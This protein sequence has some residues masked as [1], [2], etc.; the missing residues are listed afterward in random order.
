MDVRVGLGN[1]THRLEQGSGLRI[2]GVPVACA[3]ASVAVS[4]GDVLLH[5]LVDALLGAAGWGDI[6]DRYPENKT[7]RG[8][9]S[10]RFVREVMLD[11]TLRGARVGNV[12]CVVELEKPRLGGLKE[13]IR[14]NIA[15]LLEVD[16]SRVGVKAKTAEGLGPIGR[17]EAFSAQAVVLLE[18][19]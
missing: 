16:E 4:D 17:S 6:G 14:R 13:T 2:G 1:D 12:D 19:P 15:A 11:L 9:D 10:S 5:A 18:F 7:E 8:A 3:F